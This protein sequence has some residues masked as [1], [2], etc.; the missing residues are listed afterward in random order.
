MSS[1]AIW[2][3]GARPRTLGAAIVP[4]AV[5]AAA[6]GQPTVLRTAGALV[7]ALGLQVGVNYAND[8][9]DGVRGVDGGARVGPR[10]LVAGGLA[11]PCSVAGAA[12]ISFLVAAAAGLVLAIAVQPLLILIGAAAIAAAVLYSGGPRPYAVL[13]LG[14]VAVFLF[15]GPVATC[16]TAY[17]EVG[18]IPA[19]AWWTA[20]PVGLL[21]VAL[22]IVNNLRDIPTDR[23]AG[24]RTLAVRI[25]DT[26]TR[27]LYVVAILAAIVLPVAAA[28]VGGLPRMAIIVVAAVPLMGGI[29]RS[30]GSAS[31]AALIPALVATARLHLAV[32]LLLTV[33][34]SVR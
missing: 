25:G 22:L 20:L 3:E 30:V 8:Y 1:P 7:V 33:G 12:L 5:G 10:R 6:S 27:Y 17:V 11:S 18:H 32:G 16:G 14:E 15:F 34:L 28:V 13:G 2:W 26:P 29:L 24:K 23:A 4:V 19:Q 9:F 31:G 21:A